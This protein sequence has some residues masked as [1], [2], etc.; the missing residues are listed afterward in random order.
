M[1]AVATAATNLLFVSSPLAITLALPAVCEDAP[2][3][4]QAHDAR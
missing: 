3:E 1:I 2:S 4:V